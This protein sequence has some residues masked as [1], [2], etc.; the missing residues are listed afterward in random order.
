MLF[1]VLFINVNTMTAQNKTHN[2]L[3]A[4]QQGLVTIS[5]LTTTGDLENLKIQLNTA[6]DTGLTINE[7]KEALTQLY[8]Y[9]GFPEV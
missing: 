4:P 8:A 7:I 6:L 9:C 5:A 1:F 3:N 2:E